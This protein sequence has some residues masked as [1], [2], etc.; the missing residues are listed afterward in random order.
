MN[1]YPAAGQ[2][3]ERGS[4]PG[5]QSSPRVNSGGDSRIS[6]SH[7]RPKLAVNRNSV[8]I[9]THLVLREHRFHF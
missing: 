4:G 5:S 2:G 6:Y 1:E 8:Y 9:C 3:M 7:R